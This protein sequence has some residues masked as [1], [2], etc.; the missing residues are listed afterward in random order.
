[1][2]ARRQ[3]Q[4]ATWVPI[5]WTVGGGLLAFVF[6]GGA[7]YATTQSQVTSLR[8]DLTTFAD[9]YNNGIGELAKVLKEEG[10][11]REAMEK[12]E[13]VKRDEL[14]REY[15]SNMRD[16]TKTFESLGDKLVGITT[17]VEVIGTRY[18]AV[19][20]RLNQMGDDMR[21][22]LEQSTSHSRMPMRQPAGPQP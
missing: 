21:R 1:M 9:R 13:A 18:E 7:F 11:K 4:L 22:L 6:F 20:R 12:N 17:K 10:A 8:A 19:D 15:L 2:A 3:Q 16:Q 5:A 14:R